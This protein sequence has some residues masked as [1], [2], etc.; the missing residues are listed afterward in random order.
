MKDDPMAM[1][2]AMIGIGIFALCAVG[3]DWDW[4]MKARG[5]RIILK[6]IGRKGVRILHGAIGLLA[7]IAGIGT[8]V[9]ELL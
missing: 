8:L 9:S 4:Y 3:F 6:I 2:V 7:L 1:A 5:N